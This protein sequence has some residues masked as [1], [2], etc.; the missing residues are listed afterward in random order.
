MTENGETPQSK[1]PSE[2]N[3]AP[4]ED[5]II[6]PPA[7]SWIQTVSQNMKKRWP[8]KLHPS[9]FRASNLKER[10][11]TLGTQAASF[12][13]V[14]RKNLKENLNKDGL[15]KAKKYLEQSIQNFDPQKTTEWASKVFQ[16]QNVNFYG[17]LATI[18]LSTYFLSDL[19]ALGVDQLIPEPKPFRTALTRNSRADRSGDEYP[20]IY[21]RNLF[22]SQGL[23]PGENTPG[24]NSNDPGGTPVRTSLPLNL[25]GTLI[26]TN[27]LHSI[28]TIEDKSVS[29]VYPVRV[30]DEIA[31]KIRILKIEA[32][33]VTFINKSS[34]RRE[35]IDIPEEPGALPNNR[36]I[37][38]RV[39]TPGAGIE[40]VAP[41]QFNVARTEVDKALSD[42]NNILTQAR[43]VPNF[44]NG[45]A[46]GYKL[47][48]IVPG[49]IYDKL[50]LQN[51]D[52]IT[53]FNGQAISDPGKAFE[54]LSNLKT[55]NHLELQ[56]KKDGK[57]LNY[58]YDI[59]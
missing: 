43:A 59:H 31:G 12:S 5:L 39:S 58:T 13:K 48:Q 44:E 26:L 11:S 38:G 46:A 29:L 36:I 41:T 23:I 2:G 17:T 10:L 52:V 51:G 56:V 19:T 34:N 30:E 40:K 55:S 14:F 9:Q 32:N 57:V 21:S 4:P 27:E 16:K 53:G 1:S 42:L 3:I 24:N 33:K 49:S 6:D 45:S 8:A 50:G 28:A 47:F 15:K 22:N 25:I 7:R 54:E 20:L 37:P 35:F 18:T